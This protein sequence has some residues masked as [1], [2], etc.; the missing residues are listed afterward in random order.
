MVLSAFRNKRI[1]WL[2]PLLALSA[3]LVVWMWLFP[4]RTVPPAPDLEDIIRRGHLVAV[5]R[6]QSRDYYIENAEPSG[7]QFFMLQDFARHLGVRLTLVPVQSVQEGYELLRSGRA[8][9]LASD[10][11]QGV[12]GSVPGIFFSLPYR[13]TRHVLIQKKPGSWRA[14]SRKQTEPRLI[15]EVTRLTGKRIY[16]SGWSVQEM[17]DHKIP[18]LDLRVQLLQGVAPERMMEMV[19][20]GDMDYAVLGEH[21]AALVA[22]WFPEVDVSTPLSGT[23]PVGWAVRETSPDLLLRL[24]L[25]MH[26]YLRSSEYAILFRRYQRPALYRPETGTG[27]SSAAGTISPFDHY[28]KVYAT[29][30]G[31]DW[32]LVASLMYQES[33]FD[34]TAL[35]R[36]GAYGLM[37]M[38]PQTMERY[39]LDSAS[40]P[41]QQIRAGVRYLRVLEKLFQKSVPNH[42]ER[43]KFVLA[44]YN[45]GAGHILDAQRLARRFGK[46]PALWD[47]NVD[48][49]LMMKAEP[50][51]HALPEV[52]HGYARGKET[53]AFVRQIMDRYRHYTN[54]VK[55]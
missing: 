15:R 47:G 41:E 44:S 26:H 51:I 10:L 33:R 28:L 50:E 27:R 30:I 25:W 37:Q 31:W 35:S 9:V 46:N 40:G 4:G 49:C 11:P 53:Y 12:P 54:V 52:R 38:M 23:V 55:K 29:Q 6:A 13:T 19:A 36:V 18:G 45:I 48:S 3:M 8:D 1:F 20:Q 34:A 21:I 43:V 14:L 32:R 24:N 7:F 39:G 22:P 2:L 42:N 17:K 5:V 16:A